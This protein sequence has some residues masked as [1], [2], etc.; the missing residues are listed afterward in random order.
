MG[1]S[2]PPPPDFGPL[3][4]LSEEQARLQAEIAQEQLQ[5]SRDQWAEQKA[6]IDPLIQQQ[7]GLT[8]EQ[9]ANARE[10]RARYER[11]YQPLEEQ[12]LERAEDWA[13]P[14][15]MN[16]EAAEAGVEVASQFEAQRQNA[17]RRL[18]GYGVDPSQTRSQAL[19]LGVRVEEAKAKALASNAA[20]EQVEREGMGYMGETI[21]VGRGLPSQGLQY[22]GQ[23]LQANAA[24]QAG[25]GAWQGAGQAIGTPS[26][27]YA[28]SGNSLGNAAG[29]LGSGYNAQLGAYNAEAATSPWN[30][31]SQAAGIGAG[32]IFSAEGGEVSA[33][34]TG[35]VS[36]PGGPKDDAIPAK[37]SDGEYVIPA[38]V[39]LRKGT[40]FFDKLVQKVHEEQGQREQDAQVSQHAMAIPPRAAIA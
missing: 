3:A 39:V 10:D 33:I 28:A 32:Y 23:A 14:E 2:A 40:E 8:E 6:I 36:G 24:A 13:S 5:W 12:Y 19:D 34:P 21:N 15:R 37:L 9:L 18:E 4:A 35:E 11:L 22:S 26:Q 20:R 29:A 38:E 1:K 27:F 30:Y 16:R 31:L 25:A 7:I 17:L